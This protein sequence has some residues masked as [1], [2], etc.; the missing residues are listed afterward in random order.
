LKIEGTTSVNSVAKLIA[1]HLPQFYPTP[2]NDEWWGKGFTEW[3]N[4]TKARPLFEGHYQP[5][6]PAD[7]GFYDLRLCESR[8]AQAE[9]ASEYGIYGFCYYH[10]W[11]N[12]KQVLERPVDEILKLG[13]PDFPFCLCWANENWT[14]RWDGGN[15][16]ILLEQVYTVEDDLDHIR[17]L[18]GAFSDPRY[19][20]VEGKPLFL[21]YRSEV[22]PDAQE[23]TQRWREEAMRLGV[24]ELYLCL[25]EG[26]SGAPLIDPA[27]HGFDAAVAFQPKLT[28]M[29]ESLVSR[30]LHRFH[31]NNGSYRLHKYSDLIDRVLAQPAA[32]YVRYPCVC[33][34]WDNSSRHPRWP[35]ILRDST[36]ELYERWL[37]EA[38]KRAPQNRDGDKLVFVNAWNEWAEGCHLEPCQKWGRKYLEATLR[39]VGDRN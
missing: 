32:Q 21:V 18:C 7:L 33:P 22:L 17:W 4:V 24:G 14:A 12:G 8:D 9:L 2:Y 37:R 5:H 27:K 11:F 3:T 35:F 1:F 6:L 26:N 10:Y 23:T 16:K 19:I 31:L 36:P 30:A 34:S 39:A 13:T 38:I 29:D 28:L 20:R 15:K 25:V